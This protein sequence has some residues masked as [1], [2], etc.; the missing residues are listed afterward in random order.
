M[1][2]EYQNVPGEGAEGQAV[3]TD[4]VHQR[5]ALRGDA[6]GRKTTGAPS[7]AA[8]TVGTE[9]VAQRPADYRVFARG[10]VGSAGNA[11]R[12]AVLIDD[13][14]ALPRAGEAEDGRRC[15]IRRDDRLGIRKLRPTRQPLGGEADDRIQCAAHL[16]E[17]Y[18]GMA[19]AGATRTT[20]ASAR[21]GGRGFAFLG[22]VDAGL[23][24]RLQALDIGEVGIAGSGGRG[25]GDR[26]LRLTAISEHLRVEHQAAVA[27]KSQLLTVGHG[28]G[29]RA[30]G[31]GY[32]L[33]AGVDPVS[34]ADWP[35]RSVARYREHFADNLTD[36]TN[37]SS[38]DS[39]LT[40]AADHRRHV[41]SE[42]VR[43]PGRNRGRN[44][45]S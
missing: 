27:P 16:A 9:A 36:D 45:D 3:G 25:F 29:H 30:R 5:Y 10:I 43:T 28:D 11:A 44:P 2:A 8:D 23:D 18:E 20:G 24:G 35:A 41:P 26:G 4:A 13:I 37:E 7:E 15:R 39:I 6:Q 32:Q 34:F 17:Q 19:A 38:H 31:A 14:A 21:T 22:R 1:Q 40:T 12:Q 33:L 42:R